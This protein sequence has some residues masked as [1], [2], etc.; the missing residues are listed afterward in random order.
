MK[1]VLVMAAAVLC[2]GCAHIE[3]QLATDAAGLSVDHFKATAALKD[4][5]LDTVA[6]ISTQGG[7]D[8][9]GGLVRLEWSDA[10][11]RGF[12]TKATGSLSVQVVAEARYLLQWKFYSVANFAAPGG[13]RSRPLTV[14]A[15]EV[16][17]CKPHCSY[18]EMV[19]FTLTEQ[20]AR[21]IAAMPGPVWKFKLQPKAGEDL[22]I[23]LQVNELRGLLARVDEYRARR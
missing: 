8:T 4:D 23:D 11:L 18:W 20:E 15:R 10:Y 2:A 16:Q 12:V 19:G 3:Q 22:M 9:R 17:S 5:G 14:I 21:E 1:K 6:T 7:H 13:P